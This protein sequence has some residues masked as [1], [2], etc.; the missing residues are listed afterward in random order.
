M[1]EVDVFCR[2]IDECQR[3]N[4]PVGYD[5]SGKATKPEGLGFTSSAPKV[6]TAPAATSKTSKGANASKVTPNAFSSSEEEDDS[7]DI[8]SSSEEE[9]D[10]EVKLEVDHKPAVPTKK[11]PSFGKRLVRQDHNAESADEDNH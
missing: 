6:S 7:I 11:G 5:E 8:S 10:E 4:Q 9:D 2:W 3:I 1:L